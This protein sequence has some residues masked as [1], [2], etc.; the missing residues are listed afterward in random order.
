MNERFVVYLLNTDPNSQIMKNIVEE[1]LGIRDFST[2][3]LEFPIFMKTKYGFID[4]FGTG[5]VNGKDCLIFIETKWGPRSK[6][7]KAKEENRIYEDRYLKYG[8]FP[9]DLIWIYS[10]TLFQKEDINLGK[11]P[12][13]KFFPL[14]LNND[15]IKKYTSGRINKLIEESAKFRGEKI[16]SKIPQIEE[17]INVVVEEKLVPITIRNRKIGDKKKGEILCFEKKGNRTYKG[18]NF[19]I[20]GIP[21]IHRKDLD[22]SEALKNLSFGG[23]VIHL[24]LDGVFRPNFFFEVSD[25]RWLCLQHIGK[26][27]MQNRGVYDENTAKDFG[28][29]SLL[30]STVKVD[31]GEYNA[32]ENRSK[33]IIFYHGNNYEGKINLKKGSSNINVSGNLKS[34]KGGKQ[35]KLSLTNRS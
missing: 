20:S 15:V 31:L 23:A 7:S 30:G 10:D 19:H 25:D 24:Y 29:D 11:K 18:F 13:N 14:V 9:D 17:K 32:I 12:E 8:F 21:S 2:L 5:T 27:V 33:K 1:E 4:I 34:T 6:L 3:C 35:R 26:G 22:D 16:S 28:E